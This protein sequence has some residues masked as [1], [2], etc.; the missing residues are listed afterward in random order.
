VSIETLVVMSC[1]ERTRSLFF[2]LL[3]FSFIVQGKQKESR[4]WSMRSSVSLLSGIRDFKFAG[5]KPSQT[6]KEN[7]RKLLKI[8]A[9]NHSVLKPLEKRFKDETEILRV[10]KTKAKDEAE[11][12][13]KEQAE[14]KAKEE[15]EIKAKA[16]AARVESE[17]LAAAP[18]KSVSAKKSASAKK[19]ISAKKSVS[20]EKS[21]SARV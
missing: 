21:V 7:A 1:D 9:H 6:R 19:S 10:A 12:T 3:F 13:A 5:P 4:C 14:I 11:I 2:L 15:A 17:Q 18:N 20:A 8:V 16:E